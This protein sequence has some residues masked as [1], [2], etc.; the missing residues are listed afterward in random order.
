M[1][2]ISVVVPVYK[3]PEQELRACISSILKQT[4]SKLELIL[5]DDG[6]TQEYQKMCDNFSR[7]DSRI[8]VVHQKNQG[9]S[10]ARNAALE[11]VSGEYLA[12][13][14]SDDLVV[15][16]AFEVALEAIGRSGAQCAIFGWHEE[17][18]NKTMIRHRV[19]ETEQI[20]TAGEVCSAIAG[21]DLR[22]GG[23]YPWNKLW[24]VAALK[25]GKARLPLFDTSL[26]IYEDKY[27]ILQALLSLEKVVLL[28]D[29]L[30]QYNYA[31]N[32]LSKDI[33]DWEKRILNGLDAYEKIIALLSNLT[34]AQKNA[35]CFYA[36]RLVKSTY[37]AWKDRKSSLEYFLQMQKHFHCVPAALHL[38]YVTGWK[39]KTKLLILKIA[40]E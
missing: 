38:K 32:G 10:A 4:Y 6:N 35:M 8:K 30:Y 19:V 40:L 16:N 37:A 33:A 5:V 15:P 27:W 20:C 22:C 1:P 17:T 18:P 23:G 34:A 28:P 21:D 36:D 31:P 7:D 25:S 24:S 13:V 2:K 12:F 26:Y 9:V 11:I 14:D 3:T 29:C 39:Q